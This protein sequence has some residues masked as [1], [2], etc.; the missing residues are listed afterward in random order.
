MNKKRGASCITT[1]L[2]SNSLLI[3]RAV[4]FL[5]LAQCGDAKSF[6]DKLPDI[7]SHV[8]HFSADCEVRQRTDSPITLQGL[9]THFEQQAQVLII[10]Q[11][12]IFGQHPVGITQYPY[13]LAEFFQFGVQLLH[14]YAEIVILYIHD[15]FIF[16]IIHYGLSID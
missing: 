6:F 3:L 14:P 10:Q 8:I 4:F 7:G 16:L 1:H 13:I 2:L 15:C 5:E 12:V 11:V 9:D